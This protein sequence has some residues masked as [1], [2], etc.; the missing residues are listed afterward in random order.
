MSWFEGYM[1]PKTSSYWNNFFPWILHAYTTLTK[2]EICSILWPVTDELRKKSFSQL[3]IRLLIFRRSR[4]LLPQDLHIWKYKGVSFGG[5]TKDEN[6]EE[7]N[8][9]SLGFIKRRGSLVNIFGEGGSRNV[10][11]VQDL[12]W[13]VVDVKVFRTLS[14][15]ALH[16]RP[17]LDS[18]LFRLLLS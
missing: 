11:Q 8:V 12:P 6:Q 15:H 9:R 17:N 1:G 14:F 4:C 18:V 5:P 10:S 7:K 13:E 16:D 3:P 2:P